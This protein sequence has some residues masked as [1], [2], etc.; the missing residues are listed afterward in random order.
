MCRDRSGKLLVSATSCLHLTIFRYIP[1][2][3]D[4][5]HSNSENSQDTALFLLSCYLYILSAIVLSVGPPFREPMSQNR[6]PPSTEPSNSLTNPSLVP[7][8]IT[9]ATAIF[10][11]TY[12]LLDPAK[13]LLEFMELTYM[14]FS[15]K[16]FLLLL[17]GASFLLSY[18]SEVKIFPQLAAV[19]GKL[20][21]KFGREKKRKEYKLVLESMR[22]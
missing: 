3:L 19:V 15:F 8:V 12:L 9:M 4:K 7:F 11:T 2:V 18:V 21:E 16:I 13:W 10:I 6:K 20:K 5:N 14:S 22:I 1:P 17:A